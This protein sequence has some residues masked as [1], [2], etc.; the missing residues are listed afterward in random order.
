MGWF[1][2]AIKITKRFVPKP[3][4][5]LVPKPVKKL[6][7]PIL[8][9]VGKGQF[10]KILTYAKYGPLLGP[11]KYGAKTLTPKLS[12]YVD[13]AADIAVSTVLPGGAAKMAFNIGGF[14]GSVGNI[15]GS[16]NIGSLKSAGSI[17]SIASQ[18]V[19]QRSAAPAMAVRPRVPSPMAGANGP[20]AM[21]LAATVGRRFFQKYPNL[22]TAIQK[23]RNA[24][25]SQVTRGR[26]YSLLKRFGPELVISGGILTAAAVSELMMAGPGRRRMNPANVKALR[27]SV[28]RL[29]G[30]HKLCT[31]VDRLRRPARSRK[32]A[33]VGSGSTFVRQG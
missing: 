23:Y 17:V 18:F 25:M 8:A 32:G 6:A 14:L 19:P 21:G 11:I 26:L 27:R 5:R 16:S 3:V 30:F 9:A 7:S 15:L 22:A 29:E 33:R 31:H 13:L 20:K 24:G 2:R 28:R 4:K 12:P 1:S 10:G